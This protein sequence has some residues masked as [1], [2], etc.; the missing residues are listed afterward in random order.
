[1]LSLMVVADCG[2]V[3]TS[4]KDRYPTQEDAVYGVV[5]VKINRESGPR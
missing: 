3:D 4:C 2:V 1:M 5:V